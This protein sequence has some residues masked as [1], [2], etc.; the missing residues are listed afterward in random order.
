MPSQ[1]RILIAKLTAPHGIR[2]EMRGQF[3]TD[4]FENFKLLAPDTLTN[5]RRAGHDTFLTNVADITDRDAAERARGTELY[6]NRA[7]FPAAKPGEFYIADLISSEI[8]RGNEFLGKA[9]DIHN[10]GAGDIIELAPANGGDTIML[11]MSGAT[12]DIENKKIILP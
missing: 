5:L 12:I 7:D 8:V 10:F 1:N 4:T 9:V 2:G 11:P 6:A 3:F